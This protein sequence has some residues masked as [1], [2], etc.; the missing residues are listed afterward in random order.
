MRWS[1]CRITRQ[2][3]CKYSERKYS[4]LQCVFVEPD[5]AIDIMSTFILIP[6]P[7]FDK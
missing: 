2:M 5:E 6:L 4:E 7:F 3:K 1:Q